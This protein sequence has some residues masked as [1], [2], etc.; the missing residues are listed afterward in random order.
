MS[1]LDSI[2][3]EDHSNTKSEIILH[4]PYCPPEKALKGVRIGATKRDGDPFRDANGKLY[5]RQNGT[6]RRVR[7]S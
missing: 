1:D 4:P 2:F 3:K 5:V 7:E 6:I